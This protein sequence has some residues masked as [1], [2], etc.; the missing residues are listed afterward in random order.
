[1]ATVGTASGE[2]RITTSVAVSTSVVN[3]YAAEA[4]WLL[5]LAVQAVLNRAQDLFNTGS[6]HWT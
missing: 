4:P 6:E 2:R 3:G 1:M 5:W